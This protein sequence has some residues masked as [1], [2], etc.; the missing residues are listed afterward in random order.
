MP[1]FEFVNLQ[2]V[3]EVTR[4][5]LPIQQPLRRP[6]LPLETL[7]MSFPSPRSRL[8]LHQPRP[9]L[10]DFCVRGSGIPCLL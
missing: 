7:V 1:Q 4:Y 9:R 8:R 2:L 3:V 6:W 5:H 10:R